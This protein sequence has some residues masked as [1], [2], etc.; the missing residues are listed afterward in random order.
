MF[1]NKQFYLLFRL[2]TFSIKQIVLVGTLY[3]VGR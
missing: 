2:K 1:P 3:T